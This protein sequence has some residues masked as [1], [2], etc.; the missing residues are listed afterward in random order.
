VT[1]ADRENGT[2]MIVGHHGEVAT[3]PSSLLARNGLQ[4]RAPAV[5]T[6]DI[7][8]ASFGGKSRIPLQGEVLVTSDV[9]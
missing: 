6:A 1:E 4:L 7:A 5:S 9:E 8:R 2:L 3:I